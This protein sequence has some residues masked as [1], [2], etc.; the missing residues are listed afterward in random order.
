[1]L[2]GSFYK[3][4][5]LLSAKI[6]TPNSH[7]FKLFILSTVKFSDFLYISINNWGFIDVQKKSWSQTSEVLKTSEVFK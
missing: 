1:M 7:F 5:F 2:E 6:S 4:L 3:L